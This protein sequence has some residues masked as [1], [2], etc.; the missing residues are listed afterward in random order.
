[1]KMSHSE[2]SSSPR[3]RGI[4]VPMVT[5]LANQQALDEAAL[6][7]LVDRLIGGGV[8]GLFLLGTCGEGPSLSHTLRQNMIER[9][10]RL[11]Q[12]RVPVLASVSDSAPAEVLALARF[13]AD[14]GATAIVM[15]PPF[16]L[17]LSQH[18][19][20][21]YF[22]RQASSS[23]LPVMLYNMPALTKLEIE[24]ET[25]RRLQD[26]PRII[27]LKDSSGDLEYFSS[28]AEVAR[29]RPD[30]SIFRGPEQL[31]V[32]ALEMGADGGVSGG[33]NVFPRLF[34]EMFSAAT[35]GRHDELALLLPH[36][37]LFESVYESGPISATTVIKGL[38]A[39]LAC[40]GIGSGVVAEPLEPLPQPD[41]ERIRQVIDRLRA[42]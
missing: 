18:E 39:A 10:C 16:Y 22:L 12:G 19:L 21:E 25:L 30:W 38:K 27:G 8:H 40:L 31:L 11:A 20:Q 1:M 5:P 36:A 23:P 24:P 17:P 34:V 32:A 13:A 37:R 35:A 29:Q 4:I 26:H 28:A 33:A 41:L 42:R 6:E 7:K 9:T 3:F 15:T 2:P 14:A